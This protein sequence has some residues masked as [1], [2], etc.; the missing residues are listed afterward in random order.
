MKRHIGL[1]VA[2]G[3]LLCGCG[4]APG[5]SGSH[6]TVDHPQVPAHITTN[7]L[8][9]CLRDAGATVTKHTPEVEQ[10]MPWH[11]E[12]DLEARLDGVDIFLAVMTTERGARYRLAA[13]VGLAG[14]GATVD[15]DPMESHLGRARNV[16]VLFSDV[17]STNTRHAVETCL[18]E[19]LRFD[20]PKI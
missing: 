1:M 9:S 15:G 5:A 16:S 7:G 3:A 12:G 6:R 2:A 4:G 14:G 11:E 17:P 10:G 19:P 18:G 13:G 20:P 8:V